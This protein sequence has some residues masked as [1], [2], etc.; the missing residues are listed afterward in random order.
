ME[1]GD[2]GPHDCVF[3]LTG[4]WETHFVAVMLSECGGGGRGTVPRRH[5][6]VFG[7]D[8]AKSFTSEVM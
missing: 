7:S 1:G 3:V 8:G 2:S 4:R 6:G 5:R